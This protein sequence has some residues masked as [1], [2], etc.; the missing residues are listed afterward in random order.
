M[1]QLLQRL[2]ADLPGGAQVVQLTAFGTQ[3]RQAEPA[4]EALLQHRRFNIVAAINATTQVTNHPRTDLGQQLIINILFGIR[5]QT[6]FH[7]LNRD[8]RHIRR[9]GPRQTLL[10]ALLDMVG[11]LDMAQQNRQHNHADEQ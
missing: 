2:V 10:F 8:N 4:F 11:R 5:S 3:R 9:S 7:F 6:L 1:Q